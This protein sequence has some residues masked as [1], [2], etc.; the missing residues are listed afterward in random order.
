MILG[1]SLSSCVSHLTKNEM[2]SV[3]LYCGPPFGAMNSTP[4]RRNVADIGELLSIAESLKME[5]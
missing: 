1:Q 2:A 4:L 5:V 3:N